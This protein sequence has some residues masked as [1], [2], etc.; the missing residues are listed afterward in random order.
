MANTLNNLIPDIYSA[1]D[2]VSRELTGF[3]PAVTMDAQSARAAVGQAVRVPITPAAA[4]TDITP[5]VTPPND[6]DQTIDNTPITI[7]K[8]RRVPFRWNGEEQRGVNHGPGYLSIR[9]Q[10]IAQALRTLVNEVEA[11]I[12][13]SY[14][15]AS[16]AHGTAGTVPFGTSTKS[17]DDAAD[18]LKILLDN[19][20]PTG[21]LHLVAD[22]SAGA[23]L[24]KVPGLVRVNESGDETLLRQGLLGNLFGMN[25]RES[26][27][28]AR[29]TP[30]AASG[31]LVNNAAGYEVGATSI[32]FDTGSGGFV[33]GD[34]VVFESSADKYVVAAD[35]S[36]TP[37]TI[38][39]PGL[40]AGIADDDTITRSNAFRA[41][42]A[43]HR[44]ALV[45]AARA[46]ALPEEG[47]MAED[48]MLVTD[49]RTGLTFEI[50]MYAQY[51]QMQYEVSLAW[52][53]ANIKPE[54]S[55]VLLG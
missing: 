35:A 17:S 29:H 2:V 42:M 3:I 55:A 25:I 48:R 28:V 13:Q 49:P 23:N 31:R 8:S 32:A 50:A 20:C 11:D 16:R 40:V 34:V 54:H 46:P 24:R 37:L 15:R 26:A 9:Q 38:N 43:F 21:D 10:Q 52:G 44:S 22:T 12:G 19:G 53:A 30:G 36:A 47:D 5:G 33:A 27:G 1:L 4:A 45:L 41:N 14:K 39:R 6:G 51:R 18:V 7:T